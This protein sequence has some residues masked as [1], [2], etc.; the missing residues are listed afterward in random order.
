MSRLTMQDETKVMTLTIELKQEY[1]YFLY[2]N[3]IYALDEPKG[4][5][6]FVAKTE[7]EKVVYAPINSLDIQKE[8]SDYIQRKKL[9]RTIKR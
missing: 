9:L 7:D 3:K 2:R 6:Y 8:I 1:R 4:M 5:L